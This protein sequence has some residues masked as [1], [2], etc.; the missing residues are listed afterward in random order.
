MFLVPSY[1][2]D[3]LDIILACTQEN[4]D[5]RPSAEELLSKWDHL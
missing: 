1:S 2:I 4:P 5:D 3:V